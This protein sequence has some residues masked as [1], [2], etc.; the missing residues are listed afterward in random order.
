[1]KQ[2]IVQTMQKTVS[3]TITPP[4]QIKATEG[5]RRKNQN[6]VAPVKLSLTS[7]ARYALAYRQC[8]VNEQITNSN[9]QIITQK[10]Y[11]E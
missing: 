8:A 1:M 5:C 9:Y 4:Q 2:N 10:K 6:A 7:K 11:K 3:I